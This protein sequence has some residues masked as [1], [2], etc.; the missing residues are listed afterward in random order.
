MVNNELKFVKALTDFLNSGKTAS[1][2]DGGIEVDPE[3]FTIIPGE[4]TCGPEEGGLVWF[5]KEWQGN[6]YLCHWFDL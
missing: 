4:S 3:T 2:I 1:L 6:V 5:K